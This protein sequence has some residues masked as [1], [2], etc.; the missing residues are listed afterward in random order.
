VQVK[1]SLGKARNAGKD[2]IGGL[3]P[4]EGFRIRMMSSDKLANRRL[5]LRH[6]AV[7]AAPRLL[8]GQLGEPA[9]DQVQPGAVGRGEVDVKARPFRQPVPNQRH[10][11]RPV[12]VHDQMHVEVARHRGINGVQELPELSR[13]M[14]LMKLRDQLTRLHI[15]RGKQSGR[16]V[17]P[18]VMRAALDL[19]QAHRRHR[20]R[21]I[22]GLNLRFLIDAKHDGMRRRLHVQP[23]DILVRQRNAERAADEIDNG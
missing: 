6:A 11:M 7:H 19:A 14:S 16:P 12:V 15:E 2:L 9:L 22:Q 20:L 17:A 3:R 18:V 13:A 5:E 21:P 23:D 4:D 8:I 10:L 1:W